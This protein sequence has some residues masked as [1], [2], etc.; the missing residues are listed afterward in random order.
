MQTFQSLYDL[1]FHAVSSIQTV[2]N[3]T[4]QN[5]Y[6][7]FDSSILTKLTRQSNKAFDFIFPQTQSNKLTKSITCYDIVLH[8]FQQSVLGFF[9]VETLG[10][11]TLLH[12]CGGKGP[13]QDPLPLAATGLPNCCQKQGLFD[14]LH[15]VL[16]VSIEN[17]ICMR[18][19]DGQ[20]WNAV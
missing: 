1:G 11:S 7:S 4:Y 5:C 16:N 18:S 8:S 20:I 19:I 12:P 13:K 14:I 6:F 17:F 10:L 15:F 3:M 9:R 2:S